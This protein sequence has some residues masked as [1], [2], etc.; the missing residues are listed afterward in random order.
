MFRVKYKKGFIHLLELIIIVML[1]FGI[2]Y[3][4]SIMQNPNIEWEKIK[5]KAMAY[6]IVYSMQK[7][8]VDWNDKYDVE[9]KLEDLNI[10]SNL[11]YNLRIETDTAVTD[12]IPNIVKK[13]VTVYMFQYSETQGPMKI[14]FTLG[15]RY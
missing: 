4:L 11:V 13:S 5:L 15:Y 1:L 9:Q 12:V 7:M 10:P 6:D 8:G 2:L 14:I 3:Q